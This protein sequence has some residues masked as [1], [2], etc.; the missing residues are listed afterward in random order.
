[1]KYLIDVSSSEQL[2]HTYEKQFSDEK[3]AA[4]YNPYALSLAYGVDSATKEFDFSYYS[5]FFDRLNA[6]AGTMAG[7]YGNT[8]IFRPVDDFEKTL[9]GGCGA[10]STDFQII[11]E[12]TL[13]GG[14]AEI[15]F[16]FIAP[17]SAEYCFYTP[18]PAP[19]ETELS[20]NGVELG[21]YLGSDT[22]HMVWLG[23]FEENET[24]EVTISLLEDSYQN[25]L[26]IL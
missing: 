3:Y 23:W 10:Q 11:Y 8:K 13:E 2:S 22:N 18:S 9:S 12:S 7:N 25:L 1:V 14:N 4:Y 5:T 26:L 15:T 6:M 21:K 24:V 17:Q 16:R 19:V 20:V